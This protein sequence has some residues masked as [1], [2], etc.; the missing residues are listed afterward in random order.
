MNEPII[1][2]A[3]LGDAEEILRI[4]SYYVENTAISFEYKSPTLSEFK[5]RMSAIMKK[6]PYLVLEKDGEIK[7]YSYANTF[8]DR[9]AYDWSVELTIYINCNARKEGYGSALYSE[10]EEKLKVM[11]I[12]NL[13]ACIGYPTFADDEY[14]DRN[15]ALFHE[16]MGFRRVGTFKD[17]GRKFGRWYSMIWMEK[18]IGEHRVDAT[19]VKE[20]EK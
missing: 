12:T 19:A 18:I 13:Y 6:Y 3:T 5:S 8:K 14:L 17:C 20:Y 15:S 2:N 7:G 1:R 16:H 9:E 11:G 10:L 4:Y